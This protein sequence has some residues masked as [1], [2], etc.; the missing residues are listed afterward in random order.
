MTLHLCPIHICSQAAISP[1]LL[2]PA[3][4]GLLPAALCFAGL[5]LVAGPWVCVVYKELDDVHPCLGLGTDVT[6]GRLGSHRAR[7]M[8]R[9]DVHGVV[10]AAVLAISWVSKASAG[11]PTSPG[12]LDSPS[13]VSH[14]TAHEGQHQ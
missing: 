13:G 10:V 11:L 5:L 6:S 4:Q 1:L 2:A 8:Q 7:C 3:P 14:M 12:G 9:Y